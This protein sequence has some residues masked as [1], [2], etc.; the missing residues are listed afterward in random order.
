MVSVRTITYMAITKVLQLL[1]THYFHIVNVS[2]CTQTIPFELKQSIVFPTYKKA[3][4]NDQEL[5]SYRPISNIPFLSKIMEK[6]VDEQIT[7]YLKNNNLQ[8]VFQS[9]Y[10]ANHSVETTLL[11][12]LNDVYV[13]KEKNKVTMLILIDLSAAFDTIDHT[14]LFHML[15]NRLN[16]QW[17]KSYLL[18]RSQKTI[19]YKSQ[20]LN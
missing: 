12:M 17:L 15:E 16:F 18:G 4:L 11:S 19:I 7:D 5:Q 14:I 1:C 9:G 2:F 20:L 8:E 13:S 10:K 3:G 6:L